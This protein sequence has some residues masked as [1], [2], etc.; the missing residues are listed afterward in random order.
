MQK[1][2]I[3]FQYQ[4]LDDIAQLSNEDQVLLQKARGFTKNAYAPYSKF[5]VAA[6]VL[7]DNGTMLSGTNQENAS[8]P[9]TICAE[10]TL[11]STIANMA[12]DQK[13]VSMA[14]SYHNHFKNV[15][16]QA[17]SP[18][19]MCRQALVEWEQRQKQPFKI[20]LG[21]QTGEIFII[22]KAI[23]LLP[24]SFLGEMIR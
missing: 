21:G 9:V 23:D 11:L 4:Q 18:C 17:I 14:I 19:G 10:R 15:N 1:K 5:N 22:E 24:L 13:I 6:T 2:E 7:L 8:Y 3:V 16:N 20:I 12:P